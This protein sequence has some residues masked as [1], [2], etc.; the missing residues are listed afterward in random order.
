MIVFGR[1]GGGMEKACL[2][3]WAIAILSMV[4]TELIRSVQMLR[5]K[6][7]CCSECEWDDVGLFT[8]ACEI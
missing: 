3:K 5:A 2:A 1:A 4:P 6:Q 7:C 8:F